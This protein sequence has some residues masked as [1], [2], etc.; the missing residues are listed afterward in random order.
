MIQLTV[1]DLIEDGEAGLELKLL[2][3]SDGISKLIANYRIQKSGL[4]LTGLYNNIHSGRIQILGQNEID[5]LRTLSF[6]R[7]QE[8]LEGVAERDVPCFV[9]TRGIS[10]PPA[11]S[12]LSEKTGISILGTGLK[13]STFIININRY[14]EPNLAA[15]T[16]VHG[17]LLDVLGV[18]VLITGKSGIGKSE[19]ALELLLKGHRLVADDIVEVKKSYPSTVWGSCSPVTK[20]HMEIRG[21]GIINVADLFG[22]I[23]VRERKKI[24]LVLDL[25]GWA[26]N[27]EYDR[28]GL[29][30]KTYRILDVE[31]PLMSIPVSQG[32]NLAAIVEVAARNYVLQEKGIHSALS[33]RKRLD[34]RLIRERIE[35]SEE[36]VRLSDSD[37]IE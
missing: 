1:S 36:S 6:E 3:G 13:S 5:F 30:R 24:Q 4:A 29:E 17:V 16:T 11:L 7:Q 28:L 8:V 21:L 25:V 2:C 18:G 22:V 23:A 37:D 20:N 32:R 10:I 27:V 26:G 35:G 33:F 12:V 19:C 31:L 34:A 14:L 9:I 15:S